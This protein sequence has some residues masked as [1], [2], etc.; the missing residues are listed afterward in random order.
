MEWKEACVELGLTENDK[1]TDKVLEEGSHMQGGYGLRSLFIIVLLELQ[2]TDALALWNKYKEFIS[3]D[4]IYILQRDFP[5]L[6][7]PDGEQDLY[8]EQY[9]LY[10]IN[11][12]LEHA[13]TPK[14]IE[15]LARHNLPIPTINFDGMS[16]IPNRLL[17][18]ETSYNITPDE[19]ELAWNKLNPD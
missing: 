17:R 5:T 2:P 14:C 11:S 7:I 6:Q 8:A 19:A 1:Y 4:C 9:A 12:Q 10:L 18:E 13:S 15:D 16:D 3:S